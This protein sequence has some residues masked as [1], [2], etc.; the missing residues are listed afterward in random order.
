MPGAP[1]ASSLTPAY[2]LRDCRSADLPPIVLAS[3]H[4]GRSYPD[5][6][7]NELACQEVDLRRAEDAWMDRI[8]GHAAERLDLP[9][10]AA[11]WGRTFLDLNRAAGELDPAVVEDVPAGPQSDRLRAGLGVIPRVATPG[12]S[13]YRRRLSSRE[14]RER[15]EAVHGHYHR[16]L[17]QLLARARGAH[18]AVLLIDCHSMPPLRRSHGGGADIVIGDRHGTSCRT[19]IVEMLEASLSRHYAVCRNTPYAGG[20]TTQ[21]Y[22]R[23]EDGVNVL[24]VEISRSLYMDLTTL[25]P[26]RGIESVSARLCAA[27]SELVPLLRA[28]GERLPLAAE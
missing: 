1:S 14:A 2:T 19:D 24:Q 25:L 12:V 11:R 22:G 27:I 10:I 26:A 7:L 8:A 18:P 23:P 15:I 17:T 28:G 13:L 21:H 16:A 20:F 6:F 3:P 5:A 9:L 4:S